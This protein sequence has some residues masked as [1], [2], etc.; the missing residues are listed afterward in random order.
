[1]SV[2]HIG[3]IMTVMIE[4]FF[5]HR[6][7]ATSWRYGPETASASS[8]RTQRDAVLQQCECYRSVLGSRPHWLP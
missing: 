7:L 2:M 6:D 8:E 3:M 1:M 5:N 4:L